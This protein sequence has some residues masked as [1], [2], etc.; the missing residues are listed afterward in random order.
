[1]PIVPGRRSSRDEVAAL[2]LLSQIKVASSSVGGP[3]TVVQ[4][5]RDLKKALEK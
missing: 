4:W 2:L 1:M 5:W 3:E